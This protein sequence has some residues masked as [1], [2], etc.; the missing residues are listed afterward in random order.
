MVL[1]IEVESTTPSRTLRALP[2][3]SVSVAS[4][5]GVLQ[6]LCGSDLPL[7]QDGVQSGDVLLDG[8]D[9]S[10]VLL[11]A[12][13]QLE[14]QLEDLVLGLGEA[15]HDLVVRELGEVGLLRHQLRPPP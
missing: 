12:G 11:L 5:I 2:R 1:S 4:A 15:T 7:A 10:E 13:G 8:P 9:A 3:V 6:C 14:P